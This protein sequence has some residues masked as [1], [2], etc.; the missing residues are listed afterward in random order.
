LY[1]KCESSYCCT[2]TSAIARNFDAIVYL[3]EQNSQGSKLADAAKK[4]PVTAI[5]NPN[6][7]P[8]KGPPN[9]DYQQGI[10]LLK[11]SGIKVIGYVKTGYGKRA[12]KSIKTDIDRYGSY[13]IDG[14]F[15]DE[16]AGTPQYLAYYD[17][18]QKY[19]KSRKNL[20]QRLSIVNPGTQ[21]DE[22]FI[23][24][25]IDSALTFEDN[26]GKN[27]QG[28]QPSNYVTKYPRH[29]FALLLHGVKTIAEMQQE[30]NTA[31]SRHYGYV[32]ITNDSMI[33]DGNPWDTFPSYW[34]AEVDYIATLNK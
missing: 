17:R 31:R 7:G 32:Y 28:Y 24:L 27:W 11:Q 1:A 16:T 13:Q 14:I 33:P 9:Q 23:K 21:I 30:L 19:I 3:S 10:S 25:P 15:L 4:V 29:R 34:S 2:Q 12:E 26:N 20:G 5:I 8:D 22:S 18:L 6:N